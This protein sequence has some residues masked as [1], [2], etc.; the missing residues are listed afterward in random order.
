MNKIQ[1]HKILQEAGVSNQLYNLLETGRDDE[2]LCL[3]K[4]ENKWQVFYEERGVKTTN[5]FF[6][7]ESEACQFIYEQLID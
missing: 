6:D 7:T 2:R 3:V 5:K 1:L 4:K